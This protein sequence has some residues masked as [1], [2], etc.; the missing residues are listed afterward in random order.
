MRIFIIS[1]VLIILFVLPVLSEE[2]QGPYK[3]K[4]IIVTPSRFGATLDENSRSIIVMDRGA[5]RY[6]AY[7]AIPD[8]IG[9]VGGTDIRRRGPEGVQADVSIRGTTFEQNTVLLDG[10]KMNDPQ[11]G[12]FNLDLPVT[13]M[14]VDRIEVLKGPASSLYGP[15]AFGGVINIIT[16]RPEGKSLI[17]DSEGGSFDYF[18]GGVY[19]TYPFAALNN[20]FSF[21]ESRSTGYMPETEFKI[22]SLS[23]E[24]CVDTFL[25][26]YDFL[27]GYLKK[28]FGADSFYSNLFSNEEEHTDTRFFKIDGSFEEGPV[29][30]S[31]KL[32]LRRHRD[33][34]ILDRNRPGW[35]TSYHTTYSYGGEI[36]CVLDNEFLGA[37]YGLELSQDTIDSTSLQTHSR[38]QDGMFI[39]L[40]PKIIDDLVINAGAREDYFTSFGWQCSPSIGA[41][42]H[43]VKN[44]TLR[45]S[46]GRAYR[47]PTFTDLYYNDSGNK[48]DA[49]LRPESS[50]NYEAGADYRMGPASYSATVF[51]RDSFDTI[52]WIR[53]TTVMPWQASNIGSVSTNG[54][55]LSL[56]VKPEKIIGTIP[57]ENA[58]ISY[59]AL[60][61]YR[62]H[63]YLSKYALDYLKAQVS[64]G[65]GLKLF[66]F[67][68]YWVLNYKK[69]V[70]QSG[71]I[72][73]D[74][75]LSKEIVHKGN[76]MFE[77]FIEAS[78]L[79]DTDYSEQSSIP[80]P[81][82][83]LKSGARIEF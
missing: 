45:G 33:K 54:L 9:D 82:R 37:A 57:V 78:N 25:G 6:S 73:V 22:L 46:I 42:Y 41:N 40:S 68:N 55:E 8:I 65:A 38:T 3:L 48:G 50:W 47:I 56:E 81:G 44:L 63:D 15:N 19:F 51:H 62:K 69:R 61:S 7:D 60:D 26:N 1:A 52:D 11:T 5:L 31:P 35:Q 30:I 36:A 16:K 74:T 77:A 67:K 29:K 32:F 76:I 70:G 83:W 34:F 10:V 23:N 79:L 53:M 75:K 71:F 43:L 39:E 13:M 72:V 66:G 24:T 17:L 18:K 58:F 12:H 27:F 2:P 80:M 4:P 28:D 64:V 49:N 14:D 59:T 21:E 20:R